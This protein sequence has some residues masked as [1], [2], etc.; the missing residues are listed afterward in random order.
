MRQLEK[1]LTQFLSDGLRQVDTIIA[2]RR[3]FHQKP[4]I[5]NQ[6]FET[7]ALLKKELSRLGLKIHDSG[8][9]TGLWADLETGRDGPT[10]AVRTDIDALPVTEKT[11]LPFASKINGKMHAC[12]HDVHMAVLIGTARLLAHHKKALI[13]RVRFIC[14]PAEERPPGGAQPLIAAGVLKNPKVDAILALHV[15]P[16]IPTGHIGVRDG[17]GMASAYDFDLIVNGR[18]SHAAFPHKSVDAITVA[19]E[20]IS[21]LQQVVSR[22]INP[23]QPAVVTLGIIKGGT[24]RNVIAETV[25]IEGTARSLDPH[26]SKKLPRLIEKTAV[27]SEKRSAPKSQ[28]SQSRITRRWFPI[29]KSMP[30]LPTLIRLFTPNGKSTSFRLSWGERTSRT[31]C[32]RYR[33]PCSGWVSPTKRLALTNHGIIPLSRSTKPPSQPGIPLWRPQSPGYYSPPKAISD[34]TAPTD[35]VLVPIIICCRSG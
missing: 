3:R 21:G 13:G 32:K 5:A 33:E 12:G 10:V 25:E 35:F 15:D 34:E 9:P 20:V 22:M 24:A 8:Q 2:L 27:A 19:A 6:E 4:E 30:I 11:G 18:S 29:P 14:Q 7:T 28:F 31:M 23:V 16:S 26:L 1:L 17:V